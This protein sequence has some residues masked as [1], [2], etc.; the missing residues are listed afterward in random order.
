MKV[1]QFSFQRIMNGNNKV[2]KR[3]RKNRKDYTRFY[4]Y[5][6]KKEMVYHSLSTLHFLYDSKGVYGFVRMLR[7]RSKEVYRMI[8]RMIFD[9]SKIRY[10]EDG[11]GTNYKNED[12]K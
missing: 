9:R 1:Q 2:S 8:H 3:L 6:Y 12:I 7:V 10:D 5:S 4:K 11:L